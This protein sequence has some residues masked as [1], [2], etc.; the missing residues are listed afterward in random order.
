MGA[1]SM[2]QNIGPGLSVDNI[3]IEELHYFYLRQTN[4]FISNERL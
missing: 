4:G 2:R 1:R 3:D